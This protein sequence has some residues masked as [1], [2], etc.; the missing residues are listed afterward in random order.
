MICV[1]TIHLRCRGKDVC[2][3]FF[4]QI[5]ICLEDSNDISSLDEA[6]VVHVVA[7]ENA[8]DPLSHKIL[9]SETGCTRDKILKSDQAIFILIKVGKGTTVYEVGVMPFCGVS[10]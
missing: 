3:E 1:V 6:I 5:V 10:W 9:L 4:S 7:L 8:S 2:T